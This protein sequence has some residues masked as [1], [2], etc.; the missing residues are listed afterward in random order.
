[1]SELQKII[2]NGQ[3]AAIVLADQAI[4][5]D[6]LAET[7]ERTVKA[8]CLYAMEVA[9]GLQPGPYTDERALDVRPPRRG[10]G[11]AVNGT[12]AGRRAQRPRPGSDRRG[13]ARRGSRGRA[14]AMGRRR[15]RAVRVRLAGAHP[16]RAAPRD[17]GRRRVISPT[18][19]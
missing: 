11:A 1:M 19:G 9:D 12:R 6:G 15:R 16:R 8:M 3:V 2:Y 4:I 13:G 17:R 18:P 7:D 10:A 5:L 14:M